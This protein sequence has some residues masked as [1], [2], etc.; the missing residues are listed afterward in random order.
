MES[1]KLPMREVR[2]KF[3][4]SELAI[5]AWRSAELSHNMKN[6]SR[7]PSREMLPQ[8]DWSPKPQGVI[9]DRELSILEERLGPIAYKIENEKGE[10][11]LRKL[12]GDEA[13]R[14]MGA[15]GINVGGRA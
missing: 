11:D 8:G 4:K 13:V 9:E 7:G 10:L 15:L 5:M 2:Q 1:F 14:F 12:T 6:R 3:T